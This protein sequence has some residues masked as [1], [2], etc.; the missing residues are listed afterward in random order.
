MTPLILTILSSSLI[1]AIFK[2]FGKYSVDTFQ[3]IVF[4]YFTAFVCGIFVTNEPWGNYAGNI[5]SWGVI[6][7]ICS[8]LFISLFLLM[9]KSAQLN[10]VA[11]TS[12]AV[13]MS[14]AI[15]ILAMI[16]YYHEPFGIIKISGIVLAFLGVYLVSKSDGTKKQSASWMLFV[17]FIGSGI[18]DFLL[19]F[20]QSQPFLHFN[21]SMFTAFGFL[22]AGIIGLFILIIQL[23]RKKT[24]F[25]FKNVI[26]G[27]ILGIPN[28]FS[29]YMLIESYSSTSLE[30]STVL[31]ISN[32]GIVIISN[33]IGFSIFKE[34]LTK[35]KLIGLV[36]SITAIFVL[37]WAQG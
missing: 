22:S 19:N 13:K 25:A 36:C 24:K 10:G 17:L 1:F 4:N 32:V 12:V 35:L 7:F 29:I 34:K 16:V 21:S 15:S 28:Y 2:L 30:D 8:T 26:A 33:I 11:R 9:G 23:M 20:V 37:F 5:E 18:L 14:M 27:I 31:S 3:A 6:A